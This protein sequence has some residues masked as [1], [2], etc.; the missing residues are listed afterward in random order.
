MKDTTRLLHVICQ[1]TLTIK[2]SLLSYMAPLNCLNDHKI[3][4]T[5]NKPIFHPKVAERGN[6]YVSL[7]QFL[8]RVQ[9]LGSSMGNPH[10]HPHHNERGDTHE[11]VFWSSFLTRITNLVNWTIIF[12]PLLAICGGISGLQPHL[13]YMTIIAGEGLKYSSQS[14]LY[15]LNGLVWIEEVFLCRAP[16]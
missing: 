4:I 1:S 14:P 12:T 11:L 15:Y 6:V 13:P 7:A 3:N 16:S 9:F 8:F 5:K 10:F 2:N